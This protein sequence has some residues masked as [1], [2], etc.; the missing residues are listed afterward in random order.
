MSPAALLLALLAAPA[1]AQDPVELKVQEW[2]AKGFTLKEKAVTPIDGLPVTIA[3]YASPD[4]SGDRLEGYVTM[5]GKAYLGF[6]HPSQTE[7]LELDSSPAGQGFLDL[8]DEGGHAIAYRSTLRA[9]NASTLYLLK[10]R[11]FKFSLAKSFPEGRFDG[12]GDELVVVSRDLPLGRFLSVGCEEFGAVSQ[13]AFRTRLY[14]ARGGKHVEISSRRPEFYA[15]EIAR[16]EK[17]MAR[18]KGDL[19]KHA[20]EY[21]GLALSAYYDYAAR[22][23]ARKGWERQ[24][25]FFKLPAAAPK[26]VRACF[27]TI[28]QD[29]RAR[30]N[31]PADWP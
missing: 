17:T 4:G 21:L 31:I 14:V 30:L 22:G 29:L 16:K 10:Y 7:T 15:A 26:S 8:F 23:E 19:E 9:L 28:R 6:S 2:A 11:R 1:L 3:V 12:E 20:G 27:E 24:H 18:L 5:K 13:T 25:E